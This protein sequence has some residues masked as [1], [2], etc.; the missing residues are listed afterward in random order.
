MM[1]PGFRTIGQSRASAV[2]P[3]REGLEPVTRKRRQFTAELKARLA[4]AAM[5]EDRRK[6]RALALRG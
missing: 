4:L 1:D 2:L 6:H 3:A 5:K